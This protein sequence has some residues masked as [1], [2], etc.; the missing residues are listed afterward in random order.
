MQVLSVNNIYAPGYRRLAAWFI[1]K[2]VI[3]FILGIIL[4]NPHGWSNYADYDWWL[5]WSNFH[6]TFLAYKAVKLFVVM[7]YYATMESSKFQGTIGKLVMGIKVTDVN[8]ERINFS[9][10]L[11]R[12]LSKIISGIVLMIGYLMILFDSKKQGLHDKIADT[13]VVK[14]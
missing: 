6:F 8:G 3:G 14:S 5:N 7:L 12:N 11:L 13:Y 1:D 4:W 2:M 9:K 10:A